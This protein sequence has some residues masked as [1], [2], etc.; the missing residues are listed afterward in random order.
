MQ[1]IMRIWVSA[2][3]FLAFHLA[4]AAPVDINTA[5]AAEISS[6]LTGIGES[7]ASAIVAYR[8]EHGAFESVDQ[9]L[10]VNGIG[11]KTL[12]RIRDDILLKSAP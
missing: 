8:D 3:L 6:A 7:K 5:S 9:L 11:E 4:W 2:L 10:S 12:E 1:H